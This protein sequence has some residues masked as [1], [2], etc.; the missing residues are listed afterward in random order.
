M[1]EFVF[2]RDSTSDCGVSS[3]WVPEKLMSKLVCT[4]AAQFLIWSSSFLQVTRTAIEARMNSKFNQIGILTAK[5]VALERLEK[6]PD[7]Q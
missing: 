1:D 6:Y 2:R 5:F 7:L 4:L 3:P